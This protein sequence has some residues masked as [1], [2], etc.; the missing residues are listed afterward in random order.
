MGEGNGEGNTYNNFID[1][2]TG[3]Y[4]RQ[5]FYQYTANLLKQHPDISFCLLYWNVRKFKVVNDL[6]G[7]ESGDKVLIYLANALKE[8]FGKETASYGRLE[9][10]NFVCCVPMDIIEQE[11]WVRLGDVSFDADDSEYHFYSC[12]GLYK[13]IDPE[14]SVAK[15]VDR[16]RVAMDTVKN[17]YL[18]PYAWYEESMW[19]SM[20]EE[21]Q[22]NNAF[23]KAITEKQFKVFYQPLCRATDGVITGAEALVRWE[24]PGEGMISPGK[25]IPIFEKNG[26]VSILDHYVWG[27]VCRMQKKRIDQGLR[28]VPVSINVSRVEFYN[29]HLCEEIYDIVQKYN[30]PTDLIKIEIT[31]SAYAA[32]PTLVQ[33]AVRKLHEY[34]FIVLMDD[35]GSGA[36]SLNT[37]K[38]LPIDVLKIDMKFIDSFDKNQKSAVIL[39]AVIRMAKWMQLSTVAEGVETKKEWEYLKSMECDVVQGYYFY[40]PMPEA[41]FERLLN[42]SMTKYADIDRDIPELDDVIQDAFSHGNSKESMIFYSML[43]GMGIF[44]MTEDKLEI[45]QVNRGYYEVIYGEETSLR[46]FSKSLNKLVKE[47]EKTVLMEKCQIAKTTDEMQQAQ[48]HYE[49]EDGKFIWL[50]VKVRYIGSRGKRSLFYFAID[51]IEEIKKAEQERYLLDYSA[52]LVK[53]FDKVYRM[54]YEHGM[55]EV[56]HSGESSMKIKEK[57]YFVNFF[58]KF[59]NSIEWEGNKNVASIIANRELLDQELVK[60]KNGSFSVHY[61]VKNER[62]D[63][64]EVSAM[65]FKVELQ[66][67]REEYLCCIKKERETKRAVE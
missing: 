10:D 51:N 17:N 21:Q 31:E 7:R 26:L 47:P 62:L 20:V 15:M 67:G 34:G 57:Y 35:F 4:N 2:L 12:C 14:I 29:P 11:K 43:G 55:V 37:L 66:D 39:E 18:K 59:H 45:L 40:H 16:A 5:G 28:V 27:E 25:F 1:E 53:V 32:D 23:R 46:E 61:K 56:L 42:Q 6:F 48:I 19:G 60:S 22:M 58:E 36:S 65:F 30:V 33:D 44:E 13:I 8:E 24:K 3:I 49:R 54:D 63:I 38:D 52:A 41:E 50:N 64:K 9:G